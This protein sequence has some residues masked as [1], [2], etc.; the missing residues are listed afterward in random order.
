MRSLRG[1]DIIQ[2]FVKR[3]FFARKDPSFIMTGWKMEI[4]G[5][6]ISRFSDFFWWEDDGWCSWQSGSHLSVHIRKNT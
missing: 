4:I 1:E 6:Y 3:L 5:I 2:T